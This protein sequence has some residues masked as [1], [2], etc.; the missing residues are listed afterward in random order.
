MRLAVFGM[1]GDRALQQSDGFFAT[2][3]L[4]FGDAHELERIGMARLARE[5]SL[6][7]RTACSMRPLR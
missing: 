2:A 5:D 6:I 4:H 1:D 7:G 3:A